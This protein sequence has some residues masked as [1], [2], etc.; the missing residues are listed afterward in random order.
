[1]KWIIPAMLCV[2]LI[3]CSRGSPTGSVVGPFEDKQPAVPEPIKPLVAKCNLDDKFDCLSGTLFENGAVL[4]IQNNRQDLTMKTI[5]LQNILAGIKCSKDFNMPL[6]NGGSGQFIID[7]CKLPKGDSLEL[8]MS[9]VW[10]T[11]SETFV[12]T[13]AGKLR[14]Q[15]NQMSS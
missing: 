8:D 2:L 15:V 14:G 10:F 12:Y 5:Y 7:N 4:Q 3:A 11:T 1:M 9:V 13:A 6:S